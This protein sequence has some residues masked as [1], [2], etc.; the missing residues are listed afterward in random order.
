MFSNNISKTKE[1]PKSI[2]DKVLEKF[3]SGF[4]PT[5]EHPTEYHSIII[6]EFQGYGTITT[7]PRGGHPSKSVTGYGRHY[8]DNKAREW[9]HMQAAVSVKGYSVCWNASKIDSNKI[10]QLKRRIGMSSRKVYMPYFNCCFSTIHKQFNL[11][12]SRRKN[13]LNYRVI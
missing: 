3:H 2:Q 4:I 6:K 9:I 5:F 12:E 11:L 8:S 1:L 10:C 7:L 13:S